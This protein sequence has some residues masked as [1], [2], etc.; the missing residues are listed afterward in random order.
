MIEIIK[1]L[2]P[3]AILGLIWGV[4]SFYEKRK[5]EKADRERSEKNNM[6]FDLNSTLH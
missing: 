4:F 2:S 1:N 5:F 3:V 6:F